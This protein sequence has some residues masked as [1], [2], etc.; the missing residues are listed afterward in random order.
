LDRRILIGGQCI[1][2]PVSERSDVAGVNQPC[3]R[4]DRLS[5]AAM[6]AW[7]ATIY[8]TRDRVTAGGLVSCAPS[9]ADNFRRAAELVDKVLR[10]AKPADIPVEQSGK[11]DLFIKP[12]DRDGAR[13]GRC[14][15]SA[16]PRRRGD[17]MMS[18]SGIFPRSG[19]LRSTSV[20]AG[21]AD[22]HDSRIQ[23]GI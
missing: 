11:F 1:D 16:R 2:D 5:T 9:L 17:R 8:S 10:G 22:I 20:F 12:H 21:T 18:P 4:L 15:H 7:L 14:A 3:G 13:I 23:I 19:A 6:A